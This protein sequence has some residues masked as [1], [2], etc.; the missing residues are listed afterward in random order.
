MS[1]TKNKMTKK[2]SLERAYSVSP[3][4]L[5]LNS[6]TKNLNKTFNFLC[7]KRRL[8]IRKTAPSRTVFIRT[9][10]SIGTASHHRHTSV[11]MGGHWG[12]VLPPRCL[13]IYSK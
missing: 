7:I 12:H 11:A 6:G 9:S 3:F 8:T 1:L 2:Q 10:I 4:R 13:P 5:F